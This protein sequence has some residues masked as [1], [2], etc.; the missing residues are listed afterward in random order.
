MTLDADQVAFLEAHQWAV[1]GT[2]RRDG[3]PQLSTIG[4]VWDGEALLVSVRSDTAKWHNAR[5][6]PR[7]CLVVN[8][9]RQQLVVYGDCA[10]IERDPERLEMTLAVFRVLTSDP[11]LG[12]EDPASF[13][14]MLDEQ[15][16][17][18]LRITPTHAYRTD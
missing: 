14:P 12:R 8:E 3:S 17:T 13:V 4:Y 6:L 1:L 11:E 15:R 2:G 18:I 10:C 16:R 9:G 7:V 5:R